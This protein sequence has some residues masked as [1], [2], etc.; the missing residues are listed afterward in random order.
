MFR[1]GSLGGRVFALKSFG[2]GP[3]SRTRR[4]IRTEKLFV[5]QGLWQRWGRVGGTLLQLPDP[6]HLVIPVFCS[7][8]LLRFSW[9]VQSKSESP[10]TSAL[11]ELC[12]DRVSLS[13]ISGQQV[14]WRGTKIT[15]G[16]IVLDCHWMGDAYWLRKKLEMDAGFHF[17]I[18]CFV[19]SR[20]S[21]IF[22]KVRSFTPETVRYILYGKYYVD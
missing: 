3:R 12:V 11:L 2:V 17:C 20:W 10:Q 18:L 9:C 13:S 22:S 7:D 5:R 8:S 21:A 4:S 19:R 15:V 16:I 14:V 1:G 6:L